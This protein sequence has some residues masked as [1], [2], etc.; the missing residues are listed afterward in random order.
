M[1]GLRLSSPLSC[2]AISVTALATAE[3]RRYRTLSKW[4]RG[5]QRIIFVD[6]IGLCRAHCGKGCLSNDFTPEPPFSTQ[7]QYELPVDDHLVK[8][9]YLDKENE[10]RIVCCSKNDRHRPALVPIFLLN[11]ASTPAL[12]VA[13]GLP[14]ASRLRVC[15]CQRTLSFGTDGCSQLLSTNSQVKRAHR[16]MREREG[17]CKQESR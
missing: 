14:V 5:R 1:L 2:S 4:E 13:S 6:W 10:S 7:G 9:S 8:L 11:I 3:Y 15:P 17:C 12:P 16:R